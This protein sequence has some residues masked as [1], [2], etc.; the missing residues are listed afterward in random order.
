MKKTVVIV[1]LLVSTLSFAETWTPLRIARIIQA[2]APSTSP[3]GCVAGSSP[4][5]LDLSTNV[6]YK[7]V[8]TTYT[9]MAL[10]G[11]ITTDTAWAA[12]GDLIVGTGNDT[13]SILTVGANYKFLQADSVEATG[14]KWVTMDRFSSWVC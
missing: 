11:G 5:V 4:N 8:S 14:L 12:K 1:A 9:A 7:C 10:G 6:E 2:S 3:G 13:A